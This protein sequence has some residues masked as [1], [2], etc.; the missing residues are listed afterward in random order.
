MDIRWVRAALAV[1]ERGSF[2]QAAEE[3]DYSTSAVSK[4]VAALEKELGTPLF[5]RS[6]SAAVVHTRTMETLVPCLRQIAAAVEE[7]DALVAAS[8]AAEDA[9]LNISMPYGISDYREGEMIRAFRLQNPNT[10]VHVA[11]ERGE[12]L[13][14]MLAGGQ[15]DIALSL[16]VRGELINR[17]VTRAG[18]DPAE[19]ETIFLHEYGLNVCV[20]EDHPLTRLPQVR[21]ADLEG[22]TLY[23]L[24]RNP[25]VEEG[26]PAQIHRE[27][28]DR[29]TF[30][31]TVRYLQDAKPEFVMNMIAASDAA[32][33]ISSPPRMGYPG[34]VYLPVAGMEHYMSLKLLYHRATVSRNALRF[35]A[36]A[37]KIFQTAP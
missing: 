26:V 16:D 2:S 21:L 4:Q 12:R 11:Y 29:K 34:V 17:L 7:I 25:K 3:L 14:R 35:A 15:M 6:G 32:L 31:A 27:T 30:P 1:Y 24:T 5:T 22:L 36:C 18:L 19:F 9:Q 37:Q 13:M 10:E 20:R 28:F 8:A 23:F 33:G